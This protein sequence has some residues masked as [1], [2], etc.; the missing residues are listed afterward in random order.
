MLFSAAHRRGEKGD[1]LLF[2]YHLGS[3]WHTHAHTNKKIPFGSMMVDAVEEEVKK[4][5]SKM[6]QR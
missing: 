3:F 2:I 1:F 4:I 6:L 5:P